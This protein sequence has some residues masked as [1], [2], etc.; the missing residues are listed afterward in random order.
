MARTKQ[1]MLASRRK[2]AFRKPGMSSR[3]ATK[4]FH[5]EKRTDAITTSRGR[6]NSRAIDALLETD[7]K[8]FD[9]YA[10]GTSAASTDASGAE[11]DPATVLCLNAMAQGDTDV[12]REGNKIVVTGVSI[13]GQVVSAG[14][15]DQAD[16]VGST[17]TR[18]FLVQD[19]QTTGGSA[20][21]GT[22]LNSED[23][24]TNPGGQA[25]SAADVFRNRNHSTRYKVLSSIVVQMPPIPVGTDGTN[26]VSY[27]NHN[28]P[29]EIYWKGKIPVKFQS[30]NG[31]I[32]DIVDNS[33]HVLAYSSQ[34]ASSVS[35]VSRVEFLG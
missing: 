28:V 29:F 32:A 5:I 19:K 10:N 25:L 27:G 6:R 8:Y 12:T 24:F 23:V 14:G 9:T 4:S 15:Q 31:T 20:A 35:Y 21:T 26:T 13:R 16:A 33:L 11:V 7:S 30:N 17:F 18:I 2:G 1:R 34:L 3:S 22:Q